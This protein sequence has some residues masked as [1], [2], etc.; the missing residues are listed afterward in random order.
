MVKLKNRRNK[1]KRK[2]NFLS[3]EIYNFA[4]S[5]EKEFINMSSNPYLNI[6]SSTYLKKFSD[7]TF[8][9]HNGKFFV[10]N[11]PMELKSVFKK[12]SFSAFKIGQFSYNKTIISRSWN[13]S[14]VRIIAEDLKR[15]KGI[16]IKNNKRKKYVYTNV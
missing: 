1:N 9:V 16:F 12:Y 7:C 14:A 15:K 11:D 8:R 6:R 13:S 4:K 2:G 5:N 10:V 3:P